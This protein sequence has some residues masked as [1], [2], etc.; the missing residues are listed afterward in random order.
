M[1]PV[2]FNGCFGWLHAAHADATADTAVAL[3]P[4]LRTDELTG[5]RSFRL[6]GDAFAEAG[7]PVLRF[8]YPAT[9]NSCDPGET[10][11]WAV[12]Q[13]SIHAAADWLREY[14]GARHIVL[15]GFRLGA[16]LATMVAEN[17]RMDI[18]GLILL[19]PV[20]RGKSSIRQL[21][22]EAG[23]QHETGAAQNGF[24]VGGLRFSGETVRLINRVDLRRV[25]LPPG[26][27]VAVFAQAMSPALTQCVQAWGNTG[28]E[29]TLRN[30][31]GLEPMLQPTFMNHDAPAAVAQIA[32]WLSASMPSDWAQSQP[33]VV[34][35]DVEIHARGCVETPFRFGRGRTLFGILC[36]PSAGEADDLAVIIGN[37]SGDPHCAPVAVDLARAL[38][39]EGIPSL[40]MDFSGVGDSIAPGDAAT[41]IFEDDRG[42]DIAAAMDALTGLGYRRFAALGHCS[43]AYHAFH[44]AVFDPRICAVLLINLPQF[45]WKA[46]TAIE[47]QAFP[48]RPLQVLQK[49][50][51]RDAWNAL[52]HGRFSVRDRLIA[53]G[54]R[55][56]RE[57]DLSV[58]RLAGL[59]GVRVKPNFAQASMDRFSPRAR[60]L[61]LFAKGDPGIAMLG[62]AFGPE[63]TPPN[64]TIRIDPGLDHSLTGR[65]MRLLAAD[66]ITE[67]L[68][69]DI[70]S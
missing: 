37:S 34:R 39:A 43:G 9:G 7:F 48:Q 46:G 53:Q 25:T 65:H 20:I 49:L 64:A 8:H 56:G 55:F 47:L 50:A 66:H 42:P 40:R 67:F 30:F 57:A 21:I 12:W 44:A 52:L 14:S 29:I 4:G 17:P 16:T 38:A 32:A 35:A 36:R 69:Q 13:Q 6:L 10:E 26:R 61:F 51:S 1:Q 54:I 59:F 5:Y 70:V 41:H 60:T 18:A 33:A 27:R 3:C 58:Q 45:E 31:A 15:C 28:T 62:Q 11:L 24:T 2:S 22:I 63:R 19:A 68:K 23:L